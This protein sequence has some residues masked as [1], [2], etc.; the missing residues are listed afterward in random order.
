MSVSTQIIIHFSF[1]SFLLFTSHP[2]PFKPWMDGVSLALVIIHSEFIHLHNIIKVRL[3]CFKSLMKPK[4][5]VP[6]VQKQWVTELKQG[7]SLNSLTLPFA[8]VIVKLI[9]SYWSLKHFHI[10]PTYYLILIVI[11]YHVS[12]LSYAVVKCISIRGKS[13]QINTT[14]FFSL[15]F[16]FA[17]LNDAMPNK[18][19]RILQ[20]NNQEQWNVSY[21]LSFMV[22]LYGVLYFQCPGVKCV[23]VVMGYLN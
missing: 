7:N 20:M 21:L 13:L 9:Q 5:C 12:F 15:F 3:N 17:N 16:V 10:A 4:R 18:P 2:H 8:S 1:Q 19:R 23:Y 11:L 22:I 14:G 6:Y